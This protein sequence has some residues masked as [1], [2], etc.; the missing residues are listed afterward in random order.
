MVGAL[1][2][3][4]IES[5]NIFGEKVKMKQR[6]LVLI[7]V[8]ASAH[9]ALAQQPT[10]LRTLEVRIVN[11]L[12]KPLDNAYADPWLVNEKYFWPSKQVPRQPAKTDAEGVAKIEYPKLAHVSNI[13]VESIKM[14]VSHADFCSSDVVVPV[15]VEREAPFEIKLE[16]GI[17]LTLNAIGIEGNP[18]EKSFAVAMSGQVNVPRW[19]RPT[20]SIAQCR[21]IKPA[22]SQIMLVQADENGAHAFSDVISHHFDTEKEVL[23]EDIELLRGISVRGK[24]AMKVTRP[25]IHGVAIAVHIPLPA[26]DSWDPQLPSLL[27][28]DSVDIREDGTFEFK[29]MPRTGTIQLIA[30]CDG[31]VGLEQSGAPFIVGETFDVEEADLEVELNMHK[32]F[33]AHIRVIDK[34]G[35]PIEGVVV[36]CSPNQLYKKGGSTFLGQRSNSITQL[37]N[38]LLEDMPAEE[39]LDFTRFQGESD[40]E[41]RLTIRNLPKN[42]WS[43]RFSAWGSKSRGEGQSITGVE[44]LEGKLPDGDA[45]DVEFDL[46]IESGYKQ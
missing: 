19:N 33:D 8:M 29:S 37:N 36:G 40:R 7:M 5:I 35:K 24:L 6:F 10:E 45:C 12:G 20:P 28:F 11:P 46:I 4:L 18:V 1:L 17:S 27:Y 42:R 30:V 2:I 3:N 31:W 21:A 38:Q 25:V 15:S 43:A 9:F 22:N 13:N 14:T 34:A 23:L 26:G 16:P 32:T 41:G 39:S 44:D